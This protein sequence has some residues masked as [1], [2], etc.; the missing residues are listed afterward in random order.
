MRDNIGIGQIGATRHS[1][2][3]GIF[4][5][6]KERGGSKKRPANKTKQ[7]MK[8]NKLRHFFVIVCQKK[9]KEK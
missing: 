5:P 8:T 3:V 1:A 2:R 9:K 4:R 7:F 6:T